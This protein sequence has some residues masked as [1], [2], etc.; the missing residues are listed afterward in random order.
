MWTGI[1]RKSRER[2]GHQ[3]RRHTCGQ[4]MGG[5]VEEELVTKTIDIRVD[6]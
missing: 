4:V 5:R 2:F 3:E 6:R 1:A